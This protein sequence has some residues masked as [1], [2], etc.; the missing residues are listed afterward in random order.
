MSETGKRLTIENV[1]SKVFER[2]E[3]GYE[4]Q[5]VDAFLDTICDEL[6]ALHAEMETLQ[7]QLAQAQAEA[8]ALETV[9][10]FVTPPAA[11]PECN[12]RDILETAQHGYDE[13]LAA[14]H[15]KAEQIVSTAKMKAETML[16]EMADERDRLGEALKAMRAQ[17]AAFREEMAG[18]LQTK[19]EQLE[20]IDLDVAPPTVNWAETETELSSEA[21]RSL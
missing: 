11:V 17:M 2:V 5:E 4:P 7:Q 20:A 10:S 21:E 12:L 9:S 1:E 15:K 18:M 19:L 6:E 8:R 13:T 3:S 16:G 14:A